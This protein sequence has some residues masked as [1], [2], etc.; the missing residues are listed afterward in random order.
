MRWEAYGYTFSVSSRL[1][2]IVE[3]QEFDSFTSMRR[4]SMIGLN[5]QVVKGRRNYS[6]ARNRKHSPHG[7]M[8]YG[9]RGSNDGNQDFRACA[10]LPL[11]ALYNACILIISHDHER[12]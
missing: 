8:I 4:H 12:T 9:R 7:S 11:V 1:L 10:S 6:R 2:S 3:Y 5:P